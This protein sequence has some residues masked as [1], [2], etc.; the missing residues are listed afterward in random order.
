MERGRASK[1]C[2]RRRV[3]DALKTLLLNKGKVE[4]SM[5][6]IIVLAA[7]ALLLVTAG[8]ARKT[9]YQP[10]PEIMNSVE[11]SFTFKDQTVK[12]SHAYARRVVNEKD[13]SKQDVLIVFTDRPAPWKVIDQPDGDDSKIQEKARHGELLAL[14]VRL[15]E[16][17]NATFIIYHGGEG[18][19]LYPSDSEEV[20]PLAKAEFKPVTFTPNLVEGRVSARNETKADANQQADTYGS[21]KPEPPNYQF[22]VSFKVALRLD[23]WTGVYYKF[24][25]SNLEPGRASGKLV[26]DGTVINLNHAYARQSGYDLFEKIDVVFLLTEKPLAE[27]ALKGH[28]RDDFIR[29]A[30]EAG[31]SYVICDDFSNRRP[32]FHPQVWSL[33]KVPSSLDTMEDQRQYSKASESLL[34]AEIDLSQF[35]SKAVD[36][37]IYMKDPFKWFDHTY[38]INVSFNAPVVTSG[39]SAS[40]PVPARSGEPLPPNGGPPGQAYLTFVTAVAKTTNFQELNQLLQAAQSAS[41]SAEM[42]RSLASVPA[43]KQDETFGFLRGMLTIP[44]PRVESGFISGDKATLWVTGTEN[45]KNVRARVNMHLE[46]GQWKVGM[47]STHV[48]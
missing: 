25:P 17:K 14:S 23:D 43:E 46:N 35:D 26:V 20:V 3:K 22:D 28:T 19:G 44:N 13:K 30:R 11:G 24:P 40:A 4:I 36:G 21:E 42:K 31:N 47:G 33:E 32:P 38:E 18:F 29:A 9:S 5:K 2:R 15:T 6:R 48:D 34:S 45:G 37:K 27:E 8:C 10:P 16:E 39:D 12:L 1:K 41:A 7:L